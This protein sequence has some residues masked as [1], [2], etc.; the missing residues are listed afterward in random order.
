MEFIRE[1][2]V[3]WVL[4]FKAIN[5]LFIIG[6]IQ[7]TFIDLWYRVFN[8][9]PI[10]FD[11]V[12]PINGTYQK[13]LRKKSSQKKHI[14]TTTFSVLGSMMD[15]VRAITIYIVYISAFT[16]KLCVRRTMLN[17]TMS[18]F[19]FISNKWI[20]SIQIF[21]YKG[22]SGGFYRL[23]KIQNWGIKMEKKFVSWIQCWMFQLL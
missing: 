17:L 2:P 14:R 19:M 3:Q 5:F 1:L 8:V 10:D 12:Y 18:T 16:S 4:F 15:E 21:N 9:Q 11:S 22:K 7:F 23:Y 13:C 6:T 20:I